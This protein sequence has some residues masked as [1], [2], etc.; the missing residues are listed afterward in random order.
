MHANDSSTLVGNAGYHLKEGDQVSLLGP[1][2]GDRSG[3]RM[4]FC[5]RFTTT[6]MRSIA[7]NDGVLYRAEL[8][9]A[10]STPSGP[11]AMVCAR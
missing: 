1:R 6:Y 11:A 9:L 5:F 2:T 3:Q 8:T 10:T 7:D 4:T